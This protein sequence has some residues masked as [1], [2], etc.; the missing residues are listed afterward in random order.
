MGTES[1]VKTTCPN[2]KVRGAVCIIDREYVCACGFV[3]EIFDPANDTFEPISAGYEEPIEHTPSAAEAAQR[4]LRSG[5]IKHPYGGG[6]TDLRTT[7]EHVGAALGHIA[8]WLRD[9]RNDHE[10]GEDP[11]AHAIAR[12]MIAYER[13]DPR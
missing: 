4:V 8:Q 12:L 6:E 10:T 9:V 1:S 3:F 7:E 5:A 2:C 11:L 13:C